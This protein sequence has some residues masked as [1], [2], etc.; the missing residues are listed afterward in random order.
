MF[1][2]KHR[3]Y[4]EDLFNTGTPKKLVLPEQQVYVMIDGDY[5]LDLN[6]LLRINFSS[7]HEMEILGFFSEGSVN[8][9]ILIADKEGWVRGFSK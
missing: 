5:I 1:H 8:S 6:V 7:L 3:A 9:A 2:S 4:V